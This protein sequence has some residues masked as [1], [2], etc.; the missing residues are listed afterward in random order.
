MTKWK[1][2]SYMYK[3]RIATISYQAFY[4]RALAGINSLFIKHSPLRNLRESLKLYVRIKVTS[5]DL[6][7]L[8]VRL[9]YGITYPRT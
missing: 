9:F 2:L 1:S 5:F 3:K 4:I 8:I 7:S 6:P